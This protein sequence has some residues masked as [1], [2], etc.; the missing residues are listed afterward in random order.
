ML[1]PGLALDVL[2]RLD[3]AADKAEIWM[4]SDECSDALA[5]RIRTPVALCQIEK[6]QTS[7]DPPP[8]GHA[9]AAK[10]NIEGIENYV[11]ALNLLS[12]ASTE[13]E[14]IASYGAALGGLEKMAASLGGSGL[15]DF[16]KGLSERQEQ[17]DAVVDFAI[18]TLR[19]RRMREVVLR[20][21]PALQR[22]VRN[23]QLQLMQL[24]ADPKFDALQK[25]LTSARD[26]ATE[27][28]MEDGATYRPILEELESAHA[29]FVAHYEKSIYVRVAMIGKAHS[30][31]ARA[32][33]NPKNPEEIVEYLEG[34]KVLAAT[35]KE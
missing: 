3:Y 32:L 19:F 8:I 13:A 10:N 4:L 20:A 18:K 17:T 21:D 30:G 34:L 29:A 14:L 31:L 12:S 6:S 24:N 35:L 25:R 33:R 28:K 27:A 22:S 9:T 11:A 7:E 2:A 23:L 15:T 5:A 16:I 26:D 1:S